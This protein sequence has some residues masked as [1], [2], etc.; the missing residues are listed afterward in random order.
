MVI[1]LLI[2]LLILSILYIR[3]MNQVKR[4]KEIITKLNERNNNNIESLKLNTLQQDNQ[5]S[6]Q[7]NDEE[8]NVKTKELEL[9]N[10]ELKEKLEKTKIN[11]SKWEKN[12]KIV[13][14]KLTNLEKKSPNE[15]PQID[16][17]ENIEK[18][19]IKENSIPNKAI[20]DIQFY[21]TKMNELNDEN[22]KLKD[23]LRILQKKLLVMSK[24]KTV[25]IRNRPSKF[26]ILKSALVQEPSKL[27]INNTTDLKKNTK[28]SIMN[29]NMFLSAAEDILQQIKNSPALKSKDF[30]AE[31]PKRLICMKGKKRV[32]AVLVEMT[33]QSLY[34]T[35]VFLLECEEN[36]FQWDGKSASRVKKAR[37]VDVISRLNRKRG[38]KYQGEVINLQQGKADDPRFWDILG[39]K[40]ESTDDIAIGDD[41]EAW[42]DEIDKEF[43]LYKITESMEV[44]KINNSKR[45]ALESEFCYY[46]E[47]GNEFYFWSGKKTSIEYRRL[48]TIK[49][50]EMADLDNKPSW[51]ILDKVNEGGESAL[52]EEK[53][54]EWP[55]SFHNVMGKN[56]GL[57]IGN[58]S[59]KVE[60]TRPSAKNLFEGQPREVVEFTQDISGTLKVYLVCGLRLEEQVDNHTVFYNGECYILLYEYHRSAIIYFWLGS[61]TKVKEKGLCSQIAKDLNMTLNGKAR[62]VRIEEG[63]ETA[64][65]LS[66][67]KG[68]MVVYE[69]AK[70]DEKKEISLF[71][72][73]GLHHSD[74]KTLECYITSHYL[75]SGDIFFLKCKDS[76]YIWYG[77]KSNNTLRNS[78]AQ[79]AKILSPGDDIDVVP[80]EEG[81]ET[82]DFWERIGGKKDYV[83]YED[84]K[85]IKI[86][87]WVCENVNKT[88]KCYENNK[89]IQSELTYGRQAILDR[90]T[91]LIIWCGEDT[92]EEDRKIVTELALEYVEKSNKPFGDK[93]DPSTCKIFL[94]NQG[95]EPLR[96]TR[97]FQ[98]WKPSKNG[99]CLDNKEKVEIEIEKPKITLSTDSTYSYAQLSDKGDLPPG[100]DPLRLEEFLNAEDFPKVFG[101]TKEEYFQKPKW[102]QFELKKTTKLF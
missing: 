60:Q 53:F 6:I 91:E 23:D 46:L 37:C 61:K 49:A 33:H 98:S 70:G 72:L 45:E 8:T 58:V 10:K 3:M 15:S 94:V 68:K 7:S 92:T 89:F 22:I 67:L 87:F 14:N 69:G 64:H 81:N 56:M 79:I 57:T 2:I 66:L 71:Q 95:Y 36:I 41:D 73:R 88:Y 50:E 19:P 34:S 20:G 52:F 99:I 100:V 48:A 96:F 26:N 24:S 32:R 76:I 1:I 39:G 29:S 90:F 97:Y 102:K 31:L 80:L 82:E 27:E 21:E 75:Y 28:S 101:M 84:P 47:S 16:P 9:E 5:K 12:Y 18:K 86:R 74:M 25:A 30:L 42:E 83:E 63:S 4:M 11:S 65:F 59:K 78:S 77:N 17:I 44:E 85:K 55:D 93:R 38:Q 62:L 13:K 43:F 40:P 35:G 51:I 54:S